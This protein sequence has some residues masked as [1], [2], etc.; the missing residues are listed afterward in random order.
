MAIN[1]LIILLISGEILKF[2][3]TYTGLSLQSQFT[4]LAQEERVVEMC[5]LSFVSKQKIL[6]LGR[7]TNFNQSEARK[8]CFLASDW[9]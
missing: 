6:F 9:L 5:Y 7:I 8:H 4:R 1:E 2:L 3:K